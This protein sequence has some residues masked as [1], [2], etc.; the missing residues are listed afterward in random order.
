MNKK[1]EVIL[2]WFLCGFCVL[3][4]AST[5][6]YWL[7]H[8]TERPSN[9]DLVE[10]LGWALAIPIVFSVIAALI[11]NRQPGNRVG[12]LMMMV[13]LVT[14][15]P[16]GAVQ[17]TV[18]EAPA[19]LTLGLWLFAWIS[20][21][22]WIPMIFPIFLIPLYFPSGHLPSPR[23]RWVS[24]LALGMWIFFAC[25]SALIDQIGLGTVNDGGW[26]LPNPVGFL[27]NEIWEGP[28]MIG[29]GLGLVTMIFASLLSLFLRYRRAQNVERQQ[30]KWLLYAGAI[31]L[32][33]YTGTY[34]LNMNKDSVTTA[35]SNLVFVLSIL[36]FPIAISIAILRYRLY[37]IDILIRKTLVYGALTLMLALVF[38]GGVVLL[39]QIFGR[40]SGTEN[41]PVAIV[42]STLV[43]AAL[44]SPLRQR[45]QEFIDRRFYRQKYNAEKALAEFATAARSET[46]IDSLTG[47]MLQVAD[48]SLQPKFSQLWLIKKAK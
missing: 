29:W 25:L 43:I 6:I 34:F 4:A 38:F 5:R 44:F 9:F 41:S 42:L 1:P 30:I 14:A 16:A 11:I 45:V 35:L 36:A 19:K 21:W 13:A 26:V 27:P 3:S 48:D 22:L 7:V 18:M 24:Y 23:L 47:K 28:I 12:W 17:A 39:Q 33:F 8:L 2:A 46:E 40:I 10:N 20:N 32:V 31:F 37:D 15:N